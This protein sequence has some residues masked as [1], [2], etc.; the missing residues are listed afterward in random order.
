MKQ[1]VEQRHAGH[2]NQ[3]YLPK[4]GHREN[5]TRQKTIP[6]AQKAIQTFPLQHTAS[7]NTRALSSL[8]EQTV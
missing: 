6:F 5:Q 7:I 4:A 8:G 1:I 2:V 3:S